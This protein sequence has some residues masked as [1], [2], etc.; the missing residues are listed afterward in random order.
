MFNGMQKMKRNKILKSLVLTI[1]AGLFLI[2]VYGFFQSYS[3]GFNSSKNSKPNVLDT[4]QSNNNTGMIGKG[5]M[6]RGKMGGMMM[7][8]NMMGWGNNKRNESNNNWVVPSNANNLD[9]PLKDIVKATREG[10]GIFQEQCYTCHGNYGK[11]N[12][13]VAVSLHPKPADLTST[14]VQSQSDGAI[15]WEI[16]IGKSPMP[17]FKNALTRDQRWALVT[18][19]RTL[20]K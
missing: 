8:G 4:T 18:Y 2:L 6:S 9:N 11:G 17:A 10:K 15:F 1:S 5:M 12:G 13:P 3:Y 19:I 20:T 16:T 14:R 7:S